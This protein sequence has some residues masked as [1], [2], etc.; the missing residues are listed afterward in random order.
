MI[1]SDQAIGV[2]G[3]GQLGT[4]LSIAA[5]QMGYR[6]TVWDP[7]PGAPAH[8]WADT[9]I[10]N[11]FDDAEA[12]FSFIHDNAVITYEWENIPLDLVASIEKKRP[13]RPGS[14]ILKQLQNRIREKDFLSTQ[15]F[16]VTPYLPVLDPTTLPA[17][18]ERLGFPLICKTAT[19]GYDGIGQWR[20]TNAKAAAALRAKLKNRES[21]WILEKVADFSKELSVIVARNA[22]GAAVTYPVA[23][24]THEDGILR[25]SQIPAK[26]PVVLSDRIASLGKKVITALE[27]TGLFCIEFFLLKDETLL[28][29]EI[30]PRPHNSGHGTME[31]CDISQYAGQ[32]RALC[33]LPLPPPHL[34]SPAMTINVLGDEIS[35]LRTEA[36]LK[37]LLVIPGLHIYD[38]RKKEIKARRKMGHIT[39]TGPDSA[40]LLARARQVRDLL[41]DVSKNNS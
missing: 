23:E 38:Y 10:E 32:V 3:G 15:G 20:L 2:L 5:K 34:L 40:A 41:D 35:V 18:A 31:A 21:G 6:I 1:L 29:N 16:P 22:A 24:N 9:R 13:V 36:A 7:D 28:I 4:F 19:A 26:I 27:G 14:A 33:N 12:L 30:A 25:L 17:A 11:A 8:A 37:K 39:L